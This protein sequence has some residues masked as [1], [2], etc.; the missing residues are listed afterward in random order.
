MR[1][2]HP[3]S[4]ERRTA[5]PAHPDLNRATPRLK[6]PDAPHAAF[7]PENVASA[8]SAEARPGGRA[9]TRASAPLLPEGRFLVQWIAAPP[10]Q[11]RSEGISRLRDGLRLQRVALEKAAFGHGHECKELQTYQRRHRR[12]TREGECLAVMTNFGRMA[13]GEGFR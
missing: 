9:R 12:G 4:A 5:V 7:S 11:G 6:S 13:C 1:H 10:R 3:S 8:A 2:R